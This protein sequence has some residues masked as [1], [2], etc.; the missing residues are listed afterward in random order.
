MRKGKNKAILS[1]VFIMILNL[2][3]P[4]I[5]VYAEDVSNSPSVEITSATFD[6]YTVREGMIKTF[7]IDYKIKDPN[8][9]TPGDSIT[10]TLPK[11]FRDVNPVCSDKHF[12]GQEY[13][14]NTGVLKLIF[15][16]NIKNA[17]GGLFNF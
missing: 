17:L 16:D 9:I 3:S 2:I 4:G 7:R 5:M 6:D 13:N 14:P 12:S 10:I 8:K 1:L 11:I 15:N